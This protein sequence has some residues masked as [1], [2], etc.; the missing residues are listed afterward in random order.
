M[1]CQISQNF[2]SPKAYNVNGHL[3]SHI[4]E[5]N[6]NQT[7]S[8]MYKSTAAKRRWKLWST[9]YGFF[10]SV[11][12]PHGCLFNKILA[13]STKISAIS[14]LQTFNLWDT[15]E[16]TCAWKAENLKDKNWRTSKLVGSEWTTFPICSLVSL[17]HHHHHCK[18]DLNFWLPINKTN[19]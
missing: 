10:C 9:L 7:R 8:S 4:P 14:K 3:V 5:H 2:I 18:V 6:V 19:N 15:S 1:V 11:K 17:N 12:I 13:V 16:T